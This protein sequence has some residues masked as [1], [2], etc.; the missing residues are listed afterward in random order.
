MQLAINFD[1]L[2]KDA[3][4]KL[5]DINCFKDTSSIAF[6]YQVNEFWQAIFAKRPN[7]KITDTKFALPQGELKI[8]ANITGGSEEINDINNMPLFINTIDGALNVELPKALV[9]EIVAYKV[10]QEILSEAK[11]FDLT[12][13]GQ[14]I[15]KPYKLGTQGR[16]KE[17]E[18]RTIAKIA[19]L[20]GSRLL[21]GKGKNFVAKIR[22]SNGTIIVNEEE[23]AWNF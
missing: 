4:A 19:K 12:F 8:S 22:M 16:A 9:Y 13:D 5:K 14:I 3:I 18:K 2:D 1:G 23:V 20:K 6:N 11:D 15:P 7:I 10:E 17:I 21:I